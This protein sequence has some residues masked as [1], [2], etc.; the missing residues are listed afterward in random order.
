MARMIEVCNYHGSSFRSPDVFL[1]EQGRTFCHGIRYQGEYRR[2]PDT[3]V[4]NMVFS[5]SARA[6]I[7]D[8]L[9]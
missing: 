2:P 1:Y 6:Q 8:G 9:I 7:P 3:G 5:Y 4:N